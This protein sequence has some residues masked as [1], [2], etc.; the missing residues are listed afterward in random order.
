MTKP[1]LI[2]WKPAYKQGFVMQAPL[3]LVSAL[4]G[5]ATWWTS[6]EVLWRVE[7]LVILA[8]LA[9]HVVG[10]NASQ[11]ATRGHPTGS[12]FL[13]NASR[14]CAVRR[15]SRRAEPAGRDCDGFVCDR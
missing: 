13:R 15:A 4:L 1:L 2:Q 9:I 12:V 6:R 7:A 3:A 11:S 8:K 14:R 10:D 5:I